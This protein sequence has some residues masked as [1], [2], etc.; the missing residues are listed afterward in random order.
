MCTDPTYKEW[1]LF[2]FERPFVIV[3]ARILPTRN[4]NSVLD[5]RLYQIMECGTDP[6]YK[7]WKLYMKEVIAQEG[8]RTDP[9]YKE[10]KLVCNRSPFGV[11]RLARILPTRNGNR[12]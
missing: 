4:G 6:T 11:P 7:E 5:S 10:W 8:Q 2:S 1:K 12:D 3:S 9:T